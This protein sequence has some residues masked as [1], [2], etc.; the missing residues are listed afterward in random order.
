MRNPIPKD[1]TF[2]E[3]YSK[4]LKRARVIYNDKTN[5]TVVNVKFDKSMPTQKYPNLARWSILLKMRER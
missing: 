3:T 5:Y 2:A 4:A 1:F